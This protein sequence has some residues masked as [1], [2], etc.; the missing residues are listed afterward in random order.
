M[1]K[2]NILIV[3]D[4][5]NNILLIKGILSSGDYNLIGATSGKEALRIVAEDPPPDMILLD[6]MMPEIDGFEVCRK[7]KQ[8][9]KTRVIP[10]VM[11]TAL[12]EEEHQVKAI[13]V[14][15]DD[16]LSK[17]VNPF[18]LRVRVKSLLRIKS[19]HDDLLKSYQ[20]I[21]ESN[22]KLKELDQMKEG[23]M[24]MVVHDLKD[25]FTSISMNLEMLMLQN[26]TLSD[27]QVRAIE[28]CDRSCQESRQLIQELLDISKIEEG[29]LLLNREM[30]DPL[31]LIQD[32]LKYFETEIERKRISLHLQEKCDQ[33]V[34]AIDRRLI[35]RLM[36]NLLNNAIRYVPENG[37]IEIRIDT[38]PIDR[39]LC[40][41]IKDNGIGLEEEYKS[42][43]FDKFEQVS[44]RKAGGA[45]GASGLGLTFC[46][47]V[48]EVH[49]GKI[50]VES[51]GK[52]KGCTFTFTIPLQD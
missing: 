42:K 46:K 33:I 13:D 7:L 28:R 5:E 36:T 49:G 26:E 1:Q 24:N 2:R 43:V 20:V 18:E 3:D 17:P 29:R 6:V 22:M 40:I 10:I 35:K 44:V 30:T 39:N 8:D 32:L 12:R 51:E 11:V 19:Y 52:N 47:L 50:W 21:E 14:G 16:F 25:P 34:I 37:T 4:E 27:I 41:S 38:D 45:A 31:E 48:A 15:A 23:L 9:E